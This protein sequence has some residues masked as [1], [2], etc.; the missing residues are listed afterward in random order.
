MDAALFQVAQVAPNLT[1]QDLADLQ[2]LNATDL[3]E[4][5]QM[6]IDQGKVSDRGAWEKIG[7]A[8]QASAP[9]LSLAGAILGVASGVW[10]LIK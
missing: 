1:E 6:Y 2:T 4:V 8:L 7:S 5:M 9:Y 10:G 3:A